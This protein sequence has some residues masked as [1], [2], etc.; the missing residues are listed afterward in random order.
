MDHYE[1]LGVGRA[2]SPHQINVAARLALWRNGTNAWESR[3]IMAAWF[4]VGEPNRRFDYDF[5]LLCNPPSGEPYLP[6]ERKHS[7]QQVPK[8]E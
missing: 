2:A 8:A 1:C 6:V 4:I 3:R 5:W 7:P